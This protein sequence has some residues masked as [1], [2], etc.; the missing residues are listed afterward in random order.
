[1]GEKTGL[2]LSLI[3][4]ILFL[5]LGVDLFIYNLTSKINI[6]TVEEL[7]KQANL[8]ED[9]LNYDW[10]SIEQNYEINNSVTSRNLDIVVSGNEINFTINQNINSLIIPDTTQQYTKTVIVN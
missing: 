5:F 8:V 6:G 4:I 10:E 7:Y 3:I 2:V 9:P 1:M